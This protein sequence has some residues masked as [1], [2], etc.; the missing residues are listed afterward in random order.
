M[1]R[2]A[3]FLISIIQFFK[4]LIDDSYSES[5]KKLIYSE[6]N[7]Q[8]T[9]Y[10]KTE[11]DRKEILDVIET[12]ELRQFQYQHFHCEEYILRAAIAV[13][14]TDGT[15][16]EVYSV[17]APGHHAE[18]FPF[19]NESNPFWNIHYLKKGVQGFITNKNRFVN[20]KEGLVIARNVNQIL[21]KHGNEG[22]LFSEDMWNLTEQNIKFDKLYNKDFRSKVS[23][24]L[25][26][27][28]M[29]INLNIK[30]IDV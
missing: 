1:N 29:W 5:R 24:L 21:V 27:W 22:D 2:V 8:I 11:S 23:S 4:K 15:L 25:R 17:A 14:R 19:M 10:I 26:S 18:I 28:I 30:D 12:K 16:A 6:L 3:K 7:P 13:Y 20:R 9:S